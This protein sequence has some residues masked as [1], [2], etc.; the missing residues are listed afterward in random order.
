MVYNARQCDL[1][2]VGASPDVWRLNLEQGRFL[3][4][5]TTQSRELSSCALNE[6]LELLACGGTDGRLECWDPRS[7]SCAGSL[8][9]A[10]PVLQELQKAGLATERPTVA[11]SSLED[12][13]DSATGAAGADRRTEPILPEVTS[14]AFDDAGLTLAA[15]TSTGHVLLYDLRASRPIL[16]KDHHYGLPIRR[17]LFASRTKHVVSA[18]AKIIKIWDR[19]TVRCSARRPDHRASSLTLLIRGPCDWCCAASDTA[20]L[21]MRKHWP[22]P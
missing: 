5:F 21:S 11:R 18:D 15:G 13:I 3:S 1:C 2:I 22:A 8:D 7:R 20:A 9:L 12:L 19:D 4:P 6:P 10:P 14:L 17:V 16:V